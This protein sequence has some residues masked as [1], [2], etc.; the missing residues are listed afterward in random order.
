MI[1]GG[2]EEIRPLLFCH[3][4]FWNGGNEDYGFNDGEVAKRVFLICVIHLSLD[5]LG[6]DLRV[7]AGLPL[8]SRAH[9]SSRAAGFFQVVSSS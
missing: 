2:A 6:P 7:T 9:T 3:K 8:L 4:D 1:K 5:R